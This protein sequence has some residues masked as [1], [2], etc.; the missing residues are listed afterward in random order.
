MVG[1]SSNK[2]GSRIRARAQSDQGHD[3]QADEDAGDR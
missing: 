2:D 1:D 3:E